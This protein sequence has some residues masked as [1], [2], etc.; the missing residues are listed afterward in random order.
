MIG[1]TATIYGSYMYPSSTS[2]RYIPGGSANAAMCVAVALLALLLRFI[3]KW[4]NK[5]IE[6]AEVL[7]AET[8]EEA[9]KPAT[10]V[11]R[12]KEA[13]GFRYIV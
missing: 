3:H 5:K 11:P 2:P 12:R 1:N 8:A 9:G 7:V 13:L 4:E 6:K 10:N